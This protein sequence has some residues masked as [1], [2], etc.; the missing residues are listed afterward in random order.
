MREGEEDILYAPAN[1]SGAAAK[2]NDVWTTISMAMPYAVCPICQGR[3]PDS[4]KSCKG[5]GLISKHTF[6]H[7]FPAELIAVREKSCAK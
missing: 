1:V 4:C 7:A 3:T 6:E 2:L 5:R